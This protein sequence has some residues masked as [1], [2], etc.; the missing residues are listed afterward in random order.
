ML[1]EAQLYMLRAPWLVVL[2]GFAIFVTALSVTLAGH[3]LRL[4]TW[5][6]RSLLATIDRA[7]T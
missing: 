7:R 1:A 2:P 6:T 5:R 3:G 4:S